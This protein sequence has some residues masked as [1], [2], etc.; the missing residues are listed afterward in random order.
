MRRVLTSAI[1]ILGPWAGMAHAASGAAYE[2]LTL[3][4]PEAPV[5]PAA[6]AGDAVAPEPRTAPAYPREPAARITDWR[7]RLPWWRE[8]ALDRGPL[9]PF[10]RESAFARSLES[11]R[12]YWENRGETGGTPGAAASPPR[13]DFAYRGEDG[14]ILRPVVAAVLWRNRPETAL[15]RPG[16]RETYRGVVLVGSPYAD[17]GNRDFFRIAKAAIDL[18]EKLPADLRAFAREVRRVVYDPP[19]PR[20]KAGGALADMDAVYAITDIGERAPLVLYQDVRESSAVQIVL[21]LV[22]G[23]VLAARHD[24]LIALLHLEA[25]VKEGAVSLSKK[26]L[27][28]VRREIADRRAPVGD[29]AEGRIDAAECELQAVLHAADEALGRSQRAIS[30]RLRAMYRRGC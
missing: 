15:P 22:G 23:G 28:A 29:T 20:R 13:G 11:G 10:D 5:A 12:A 2:F 3:Y 26:N 18:T 16:R 17:A 24:R 19:S 9:A 8:K 6:P 21:S 4:S 1:L 27:N 25:R 14:L 30:A 7:K